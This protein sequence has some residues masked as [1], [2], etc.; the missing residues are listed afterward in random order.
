MAA[1]R[2]STASHDGRAMERDI[3]QI[4]GDSGVQADE[5]RNEPGSV[6]TYLLVGICPSAAWTRRWCSIS[7][8]AVV[9]RSAAHYPTKTC[10]ATLWRVPAWCTARCIGLVHGAKRLGRQSS[11]LT[12]SADGAPRARVPDLC[13]TVLDR[14]VAAI[15]EKW[16]RRAEIS[17]ASPRCIPCRDTRVY[18]GAVWR[19]CSGHSRRLRV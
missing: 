9:V 4:S 17:L 6:Q 12:P 2:G 7:P 14:A 10:A 18:H 8:S 16:H 5:S 11:R 13:S 1:D 19:P 15:P 3:C